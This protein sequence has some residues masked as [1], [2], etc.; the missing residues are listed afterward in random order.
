MTTDNPEVL[1]R[2]A[3]KYALDIP[4]VRDMGMVVTDVGPGFATLT[5]TAQDWMVGDPQSGRLHGGVVT[6]LID[7]VCGLAVLVAMPDPG[8][9]ATLDLRIDYLKPAVAGEILSAT[10]ECL[11][12]T[13]Q[14]AFVRASACVAGA[15]D[16]I[17][18]A[19]ASFIIKGRGGGLAADSVAA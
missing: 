17:A 5:M 7:S 2:L 4:H 10:A 3:R 12:L 18:A 11:K 8:P 16:H 15:E 19:Q 9:V 13:S 14:I 6:A 1:L